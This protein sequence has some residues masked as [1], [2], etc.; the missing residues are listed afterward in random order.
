M[1]FSWAFDPD[2]IKGRKRTITVSRKQ[3]K[4][5]SDVY[6]YM[7]GSFKE[8]GVS[9]IDVKAAATAQVL[10]VQLVSDDIG[11]KNV[12]EEYGVTCLSTVKMLH[13]MQQRGHITM[14]RVRATVQYLQYD[15]DTCYS[16]EAEYVELFQENYPNCE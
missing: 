2:F 5:I 12:A 15:N 13:I 8:T 6:D 3:K 7:W 4:E 11:V 1:K 16:F 9:E 10:K 14:D